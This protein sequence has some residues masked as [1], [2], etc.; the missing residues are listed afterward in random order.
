MGA[1]N[2]WDPFQE[3]VS[4]REAMN[5]LFEGSFVRDLP[6][7]R[8]NSFTPAIDLSETPEAFLVEASVPGLKA[9]DIQVSFEDNVLT[10]SGEIHQ[11]E[12]QKERNYH[13]VE[14]RYGSFKRSI[15]LPNSVQADKIEA[16]LENGILHLSIPKAEEVK[17][18]RITVNV[19][20]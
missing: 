17:P 20:S 9:E 14:R 7:N 16:S 19:S 6:T 11:K 13:R 4:L 1:I 15:A 5:Q 8:T 3:A 10:I 2:R 12:E 18:R